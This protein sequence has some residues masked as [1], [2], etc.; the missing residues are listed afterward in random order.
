[1]KTVVGKFKEWPLLL[2]TSAISYL[3]A[4]SFHDYSSISD[5]S[6]MSEMDLI[7]DSLLITSRVISY[8][9]LWDSVAELFSERKNQSV[10]FQV[11]NRVVGSCFSFYFAQSLM[12]STNMDLKVSGV[13]SLIAV[14]NGIYSGIKGTELKFKEEN[15]S[16]P[17]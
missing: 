12:A 7:K 13:L 1:M 6:S 2:A 16:S 3:Y 10:T 8:K 11:N 9:I 15:T 17:Q 5:L 14:A 4:T